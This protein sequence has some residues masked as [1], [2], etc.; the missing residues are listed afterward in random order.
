MAIKFEH[1]KEKSIFDI[2]SEILE[3]SKSYS[4]TNLIGYLMSEAE[5]GRYEKGICGEKSSFN[6]EGWLE[7]FDDDQI[8]GTE[9]VV[10][11]ETSWFVY[12]VIDDNILLR[13][14][15]RGQLIYFNTHTDADQCVVK[16]RTSKSGDIRI[17][18]KDKDGEPIVGVDQVLIQP[19]K[20]RNNSKVTDVIR[21]TSVD[22]LIQKALGNVKSK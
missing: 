16:T 19:G 9:S 3:S 18:I 2:G 1:D 20:I 21:S 7:L 12:A 11:G 13:I 17:L 5:F 15:D 10:N 14:S 22:E 8:I 4:V 6:T